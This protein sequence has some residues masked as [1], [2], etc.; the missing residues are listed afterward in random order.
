MFILRVRR[1][2]RILEAAPDLVLERD[3]VVAVVA[4]YE[5]HVTRGDV[6]GPEIGDLE[7]L[8]IPVESLDVVVTNKLLAGKTL[9]LLAQAPFARSI[10]LSRITRAGIEVPISPETR[11]DRGDVLRIIGPLPEVDRASKALGYADRKTS[12]TDMV[13]VG[14]GI[15]L[16]GPRRPAIRRRRE[17]APHLDRKRRRVGDGTRVWL[18]AV[19]LPLLRADSRAGHL[20]LR[21]ARP[22]HVHRHRRPERRTEL[23]VGPAEDRLDPR[24]RRP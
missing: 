17:R 6:I 9:E 14:T 23:R 20:D 2:G 4:R 13:F 15:F 19:G 16:G 7:L 5:A 1:D 8:D 21:H 24:R 22:V 10:F 3:D 11:V 12:A 18:A